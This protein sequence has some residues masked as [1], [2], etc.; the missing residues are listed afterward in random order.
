MQTQQ[1]PPDAMLGQLVMGCFVSQA[2][3]VAA[4]LGIADLLKDKPRSIAELAAETNTNEHALYRVLR[5]L[6]SVGVF[7]ETDDWVFALTPLAEPLLSDR[8]GSMR[9]VV[10]WIGE[11]FHWRVYGEMLYSVQTGK[12]AWGHV[13][14]A[15]VFDYFKQNPAHGE[16]FNRA[17]TSFSTGIIP[18]LTEAYDFSETA[19]LADIAGGHGILLAGFLKA[20][21]HLKGILFDV[22]SVI[23]GADELLRKEG[24]ADRVEKVSGDFFESVPAGDAYM[25]K[26]IIHDWDDERSIKILKNIHA[27]MNAGGKVLIIEMVV[28]DG[29]EPHFSKIMDLEMLVSPGGVERTA[30]EYRDL[31]AKAGFRLTRI[32]PTKSPYSIVEA[33]KS[34][35]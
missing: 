35:H 27:A 3:T 6:A 23:E 28:P 19:T 10:I 14:G 30:A 26:H 9:D 16:I 24:A 21:P 32:I 34:S 33:V 15:E 12:T 1:M 13:H 5:A 18:A 7:A 20:N 17:M 2:V 22:P 4:K 11:E 31:L 8:V 29:N 25:M